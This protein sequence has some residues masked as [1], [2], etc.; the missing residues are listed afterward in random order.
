MPSVQENEQRFEE[1]GLGQVKILAA[2]GNLPHDMLADAGRWMGRQEEEERQ[3]LNEEREQDR[4][5][6][7]KER[8]R[9]IA[10]TVEMKT[11]AHNTLIAAWVAAGGAIVAVLI[12]LGAWL[13]PRT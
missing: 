11:I 1:L 10:A 12:G 2:T 9:Q 8:R 3:R 13:F 7:Q 6:L 4:E 5:E